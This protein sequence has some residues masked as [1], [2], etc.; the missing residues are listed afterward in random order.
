MTEEN[1]IIPD[2]IPFEEQQKYGFINSLILTV[3]MLIT[4]PGVFFGQ[5]HINKGLKLP[6]LFLIILL[7]FNNTL[8]YIYISTDMIESPTEQ[9][10]AAMESDPEYQGQADTIREMFSKEPSPFDIIFSIITNFLLM[11]LLAVYWHLILRSLGIALNGLE[12]TVRIFCYSSVVLITSIIPL[13]NN[14]VNFAVYIWWAYFM[15]VGI[16]EAHEVSKK[17][18]FRGITVSLLATFVPFMLILLAVL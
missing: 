2:N 14:L 18:A 17:L 10:A 4:K 5:M 16:S 1:I 9:V 15:Y 11:Y 7:A 3:R 12:A 13:S 8:N 6:F